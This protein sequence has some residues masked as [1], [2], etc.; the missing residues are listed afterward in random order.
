M[1]WIEVTEPSRVDVIRSC[2]WPISVSSVG[3]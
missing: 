2:S 3:W 1:A